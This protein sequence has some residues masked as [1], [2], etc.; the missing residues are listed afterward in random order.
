MHNGTLYILGFNVR[1][2]R[3]VTCS[4]SS[5]DP[6]ADE[7]LCSKALMFRDASRR[8]G[9]LFV[10]A[11]VPRWKRPLLRLLRIRYD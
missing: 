3:T 10:C 8:D 1:G 6:S 2:E 4:I 9:R 7:M 5:R 11:L